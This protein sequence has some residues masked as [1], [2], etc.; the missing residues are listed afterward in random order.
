MEK[1]VPYSKLSK[2]QRK[3]LDAKKRKTWGAL[4]PVT[5]KPVNPKAY[6]RKKTRRWDPDD[7]SA[8]SSYTNQSLP[9][10]RPPSTVRSCASVTPGKKRLSCFSSRRPAS[11]G[12]SR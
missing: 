12:V 7:P 10:T 5:R 11:A 8:V 1:F 4:S 2:K 3:A 6:N 9:G